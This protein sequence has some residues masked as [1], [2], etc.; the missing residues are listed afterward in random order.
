V[1]FE[2]TEIERHAMTAGTQIQ[3]LTAA[4]QEIRRRRDENAAEY[5]RQF[6]ELARKHNE[7]Y[8]KIQEDCLHPETANGHC[9]DCLAKT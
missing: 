4:R 1:D 8:R 7:I 5:D 9:L 3:L 2:R 6:K